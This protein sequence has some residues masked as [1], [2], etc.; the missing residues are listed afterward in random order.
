MQILTTL[1]L[2]DNQIGNEGAQYFADVL[3][4]NKVRDILYLFITYLLHHSIQTLTT[5]NLP[6]NDISDEGV[7]HLAKMLQNNTVNKFYYCI[8]L[9]FYHYCFFSRHLQRLI[10]IRT[11]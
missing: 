2:F 7:Q 6:S 1:N 9:Y 11:R 8:L 3:Q 10:Y 5:L 4:A